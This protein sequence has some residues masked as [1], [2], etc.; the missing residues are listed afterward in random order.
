MM[1]R[2]AILSMTKVLMQGLVLVETKGQTTFG[3]HLGPESSIASIINE[4]SS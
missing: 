4:G 3:C 1:P 2:H